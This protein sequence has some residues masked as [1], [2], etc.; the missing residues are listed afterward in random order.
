MLI[1]RSTK[2]SGLRIKLVLSISANSPT[3]FS[4]LISVSICHCS[5]SF[6]PI[7]SGPGPFY[8]KFMLLLA[9]A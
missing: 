8:S 6:Q 1:I 9:L 7:D 3:F 4:F 5:V 2:Q